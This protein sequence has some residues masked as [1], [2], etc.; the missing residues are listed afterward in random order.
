[1]KRHFNL[2][3]I[4]SLLMQLKTRED[5][6]PAA[7]LA[8]R[9]ADFLAKVANMH[10]PDGKGSQNNTQAQSNSSPSSSTGGGSTALKG[11][12]G[13][14][15]ATHTLNTVLYALVGVIFTVVLA[16]AA[17]LYRE[18]IRDFFLPNDGRAVSTEIQ[19]VPLL[20]SE[21]PLPDTTASVSPTTT[22]LTP[23]VATKQNGS[24][25]PIPDHTAVPPVSTITKPGNRYGQVT[26]TP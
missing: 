22:P 13:V 23:Q 18:E 2:R 8:A 1:M 5:E 24:N 11:I 4:L 9:R 3:D 7:L 6:Y 20:P 17:Y 19:P 12:S 10:P 26:K 21:T 16:E 25:T 15:A 14:Q